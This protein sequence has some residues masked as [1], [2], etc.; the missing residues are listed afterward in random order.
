[1]EFEIHIIQVFKYF[2]QSS[3]YSWDTK[4]HD[5]LADLGTEFFFHDPLRTNL[6]TLRDLGSHF[7]GIT[8]ND[9]LAIVQNMSRS[10]QVARLR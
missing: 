5:I 1:M 4:V 8:R 3:G 10:E 2:E 6:I 7:T 9:Y